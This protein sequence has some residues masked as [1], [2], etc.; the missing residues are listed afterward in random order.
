[1]QE[2]GGS[3][4]NERMKRPKSCLKCS[5]TE[6]ARPEAG[7]AAA[8]A[9]SLLARSLNMIQASSRMSPSSKRTVSPNILKWNLPNGYLMYPGGSNAK[10]SRE[11]AGLLG[12]L[13]GVLAG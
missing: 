1:M 11:E 7:Q 10:K 8:A 12:G 6:L 2:H 5:P 13:P 4:S 3:P 9:T